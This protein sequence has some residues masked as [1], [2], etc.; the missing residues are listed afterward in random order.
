MSERGKV[1]ADTVVRRFFRD[2]D[3]VNVAL[4]HTSVGDANEVGARA[5]FLN[6]AAAGVTHGSA[7]TAS[8]LVKDGD[9]GAFVRHATFHTF[10]HDLFQFR[11]GVLEIAVLGAMRLRYRA[12]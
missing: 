12:Q 1:S 5:H 3:L 2:R 11:R 6:G 10:R 7:Q 9:D 8:E 4:A